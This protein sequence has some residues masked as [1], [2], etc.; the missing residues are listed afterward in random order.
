MRL[1]LRGHKNVHP[2]WHERRDARQSNPSGIMWRLFADSAA[3]ART[4]CT[5]PSF[6]PVAATAWHSDTSRGKADCA[7]CVIR[8]KWRNESAFSPF[9]ITG[10]REQ[11]CQVRGGGSMCFQV[12]WLGLFKKPRQGKHEKEL[13][14]ENIARAALAPHV[15]KCGCY[16][17]RCEP[18]CMSGVRAAE[19][20]QLAS[21]NATPPTY[22]T[23]LNC[24]NDSFDARR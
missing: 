11:F 16:V 14:W 2:E 13:K 10:K 24:V 8:E 20:G 9:V 5:S 22:V 4:S 19:C 1:N 6:C 15:V 17:R 7:S 3:A 23:L 21:T 12:R 18:R